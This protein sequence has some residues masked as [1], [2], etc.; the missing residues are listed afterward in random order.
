LGKDEPD[1]AQGRYHQKA[2]NDDLLVN[3]SIHNR[4]VGP[5]EVIPE[6]EDAEAY[7][8]KDGN[9]PNRAA[10]AESGV[11]HVGQN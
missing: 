5:S 3:A 11:Q 1:G 8:Q 6:P 4:L 9:E 7:V 10:L 2:G